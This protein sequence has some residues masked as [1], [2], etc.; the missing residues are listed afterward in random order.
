MRSAQPKK[1]NKEQEIEREITPSIVILAHRGQ[2]CTNR[3]PEV[4]D[5]KLE[6]RNDPEF[7]D[8]ILPEN[9]LSAFESAFQ[10]GA[11]GFECDVF[12][13]KRRFFI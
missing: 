4:R 3:N 1:E 5:K 11:D 7:K 12:L 10:K 2:G 13:S 9:S 8:Q 6:A